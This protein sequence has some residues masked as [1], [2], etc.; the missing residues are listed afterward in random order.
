MPRCCSASC[1]RTWRPP[2]AKGAIDYEGAGRLLRFYEDGLHGYT[3]LEGVI[4]LS[5]LIRDS[6]PGSGIVELGA[7]YFSEAVRSYAATLCAAR[8]G[9]IAIR[10]EPM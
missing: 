5:R 4:R 6:T 10:F 9:T 3:Y 1:G 8:N 7:V 2:Y